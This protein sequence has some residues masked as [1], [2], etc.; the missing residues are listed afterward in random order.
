MTTAEQTE[1]VA[2]C[3]FPNEEWEMLENNLFVAKSR[4]P[5]NKQQQR[6]FDS[7][8]DMARILARKKHVVYLLPETGGG[9]HPDAIVDGVAT[10][11]KRIK[12]G[13]N[14]ISHRFRE[15]LSQGTNVFLNIETD[16]TANDVK[17]ILKGVIA[18]TSASGTIYVSM[19]KEKSNILHRWQMQSLK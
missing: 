17:N 7:D 5:H 11:F 8:I 14:A 13:R 15:S 19:A 10:E 6:V 4:R 9:K 1:I 2:K 3:M 18:N 16:I 12:G